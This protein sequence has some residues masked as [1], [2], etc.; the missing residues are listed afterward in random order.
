M[1][2]FP[3]EG[4]WRAA[5]REEPGNEA[6]AGRARGDAESG[7]RGRTHTAHRPKQQP[8][9]LRYFLA[10]PLIEVNCTRTLPHDG[11][12]VSVTGKR[13]ASVVMNIFK[14]YRLL[15][16]PP[17]RFFVAIL[18]VSNVPARVVIFSL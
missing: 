7:S 17:L 9:A 1:L 13:R 3:G 16:R 5:F 10:A 11:S 4:H 18:T 8:A 14:L 6:A 2:S 15:S 12:A